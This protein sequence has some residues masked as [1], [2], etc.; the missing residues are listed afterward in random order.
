[1]IIR[2]GNLSLTNN[3]LKGGG[4][5][6]R[7]LEITRQNLYKSASSKYAIKFRYIIKK[8]QNLKCTII[9]SGNKGWGGRHIQTEIDINKSRLHIWIILPQMKFSSYNS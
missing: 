2:R 1:M 9:I 5:E 6:V 8:N 3:P 4:G 7:A